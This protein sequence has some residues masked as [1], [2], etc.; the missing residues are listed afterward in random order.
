MRIMIDIGHPGHVHFFKNFIWEMK[1]KGHDVLVTASD[2]DVTLNLLNKYEIEHTVTCKRY[3]GV[4][5]GYELL[6]RDVQLFNIARK[7]KPD[8]LMGINNTICAH[9]SKISKG[10]SLIFTDTEHAK[11]AN[12]ITFPFSDVILTPKCYLGEIGKKHVRYNGYHQL[13]YLHPHRFSPNPAVL[14]E[15]GIKEGEPLIVVRLVSWKASHDVG[16]HGISDKLALV[17][18]LE[19][20]GRV[21]ITSEASLPPE[22]QPYQVRISPERLHDLLY[23]ATLYVGDGG[24]TG[25]EGAMLGTHGIIISTTA[26]YCGIFHDLNRYGLMW[27]YESDT[28]GLEKAKELLSDSNLKQEGLRKSQQL[29]SDRSDVTEFMMW[30]VEEYPQSVE[31]TQLRMN[32]KNVP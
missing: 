32:K 22:L 13:A 21:L 9:V 14:Q 20:Y 28:E 16:Q 4:M 1:K 17:R 15:L 5:L 26:K 3:S 31:E 24:T 2:K 7:F 18:S 8:F 19:Q 12:A 25:S 10:T 30:F 6:R 27:I 11:L 29:I 23:Y